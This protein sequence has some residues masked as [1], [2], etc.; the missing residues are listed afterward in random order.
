ML[1]LWHRSKLQYIF[2]PWPGNFYK[3]QVQ[4]K[5]KKKTTTTNKKELMALVKRATKEKFEVIWNLY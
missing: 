1:Q 3:P 2:D 5:K 4:P